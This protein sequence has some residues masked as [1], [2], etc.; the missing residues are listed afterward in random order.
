MS[1]LKDLLSFSLG[2]VKGIR[3]IAGIAI[4][5]FVVCKVI[6]QSRNDV[7]MITVTETIP[8]AGEYSGEEKIPIRKEG[9]GENGAE[10]P[11]EGETENIDNELLDL[12]F[13][14]NK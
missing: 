13:F 12:L 14:E 2:E 5:V 8:L 3:L 6:V 1:K 7:R 10:Q 4:L 11:G 9:T